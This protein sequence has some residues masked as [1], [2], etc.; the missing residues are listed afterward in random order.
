M[1][2]YVDIFGGNNINPTYLGYRSLAL[3]T[4]TT[5]VWPQNA[6]SA[7]DVIAQKMDVTPAAD[8]LTVALPAANLVSVGQD[9]YF[10][11]VGA[12]TFTILDNDGGTVGAVASGEAW[13]VY[14]KDNSSAA[15]S[16]DILQQGAGSS[17]AQAASLAGLGLVAIS[18]LLNQSHPIST[19]N[20][21]YTLSTNDRAQAIFSTGGSITFAF[22]AS[23][24]LGDNWFALVR[25][26]GNGTLTLDPSGSETIDG[27]STKALAIG[28]SCFVLCDGSNIYTVGYGRS[29][30]TTIN[31]LIIA[32][33]GTAGTQTLSASEVASQVQ[34]FDGTLTGDRVYEYGSTAGYW[35]VFNNLTLGGHSA[36]W[37]VDAGDTGVDNTAF[38]SGDF[39]VLRSDGTNLNIATSGNAGTVTSIATGTG[40]TGG[41]ITSTGTIALANTAVAPGTYINGSFTVDAQG[42]LTDAISGLFVSVITADPN[43]AIP[44]LLYACNTTASAFS[45]TLPLSPSPGDAVSFLDYAG[46]L[47]TNALTLARNGS[48]IMGA[49]ADMTV[50][51][52]YA[53]FSVTYVDATRGWVLD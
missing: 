39:A 46:T 19:K 27:A 35:F 44:G 53:R 36:T 50:S 22:S 10:R 48:K 2:D 31:A 21:N 52:D 8:N 47:A 28:E 5:L 29:V 25:N 24:T 41:P 38:P 26:N 13:F 34:Q 12:H 23:P 45:V 17:S 43:P 6:D 51:T 1:T 9:A 49:T 18:T 16:W 4:S 32:A 11:N 37:R 15:G 14:L 7:A 42:R 30:S 33:G 3:A 40:L 20:A